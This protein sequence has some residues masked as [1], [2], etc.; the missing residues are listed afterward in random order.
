MLSAALEPAFMWEG[1]TLIGLALTSDLR[2]L[3]ASRPDI[4]ALQSAH[5]TLDLRRLW[6]LALDAARGGRGGAGTTSAASA[7]RQVGLSF[8]AESVL[9]KPLD[10]AMQVL[11]AKACRARSYHRLCS[12]VRACRATVLAHA[13]APCALRSTHAFR[14]CTTSPG[15]VSCGLCW[16]L[17]K[18]QLP[19]DARL[20]MSGKLY[21]WAS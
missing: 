20:V 7:G 4:A 1:T 10:K 8:L 21:N 12:P 16:V 11:I 3:A 13:D 17:V 18:T 6:R 5:R 14:F 9:G 15:H 19:A 2:R